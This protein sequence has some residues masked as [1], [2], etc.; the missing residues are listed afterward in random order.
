MSGERIPVA[1][2]GATGVVGQRFL[3]L[4][5]THPWFVA[6]ELVASNRSAGKRYGDAV[7]WTLDTPIPGDAAKMKL[8]PPGSALTS[9]IVFSALGRDAASEFEP[10]YASSGHFVVSNASAF[11]MDPRVPLLIPEVNPDAVTQLSEQPW[12]ESGGAI[13]TNPN[14]SVAGLALALA[15]IEREF[16]I[17]SVTAVTLQAL[18]GAGLPGPASIEALGNVIPHIA[19][20]AEKIEQEPLRILGAEFSISVLVNRVPVADGHTICVFVKLRKKSSPG[21]VA[22]ALRGFATPERVA[23]LPTAISRPLVID[24]RP[25]RPQPRLDVEHDRGMRVTVGPVTSDGTY[26]AR[27]T[28]LVHNTLRGA[29]SGALLNAELAVSA[30]VCTG[31]TAPSTV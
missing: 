25:D 6:A 26:D 13:I 29:A 30:G 10:Q 12:R 8:L 23:S 27:F 9:R 14:C 4:L 7:R 5:E 17:E 16:G 31:V 11:R 22:D 2:L 24:E 19:G 28:L 15:P 18:S 20:E 3:Q 21:K 1:I